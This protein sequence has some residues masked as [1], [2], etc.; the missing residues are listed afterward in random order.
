VNDAR[1]YEN[2][3]HGLETEL[4]HEKKLLTDLKGLVKQCRAQDM[5]APDSLSRL[6]EE[7]QARKSSLEKAMAEVQAKIKNRRI[8]LVEGLAAPAPGH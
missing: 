2:V 4:G 8:W 1:Y 7:G 3:L 6:I 5:E